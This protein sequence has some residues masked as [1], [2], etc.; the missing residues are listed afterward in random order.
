MGSPD[1]VGLLGAHSCRTDCMG[2]G[3]THWREE[4]LDQLSTVLVFFQ[5]RAMVGGG[6][7]ETG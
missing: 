4:G 2:L 3:A 7:R 6:Q 1:Q 5:E